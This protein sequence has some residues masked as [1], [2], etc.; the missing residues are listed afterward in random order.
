MHAARARAT[1]S[2]ATAGR[3]TAWER[4]VA[5]G[6]EDEEVN[7]AYVSYVQ[8]RRHL[9]EVLDQIK[10]LMILIINLCQKI[11]TLYLLKPQKN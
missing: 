3:A 9:E 5:G 10:M 7:R 8:A 1:A 2:T 6:D 4:A 11:L